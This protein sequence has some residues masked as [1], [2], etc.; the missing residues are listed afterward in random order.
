MRTRIASDLHDEV[1]S[2]LSGLS[3]QAELLEMT[4][5][6]KDNTTLQHIG[7]IS[8][9]AVSKMRDLVWSIDSRRDK[10]KNLLDRMR[11]HADD[12]LQPREISCR[13]ELGDLPLEKKLPVDMR[14]HLFLIFKEA[15]NNVARH[16]KAT[17]VK[18][19]F[20]N[21]DGKLVLCIHDN[22]TS[23]KNE[24]IATGL[25]LSNM[26]MRAAKLGANLQVERHDGF[27]I[28]LSLKA[29]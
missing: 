12:L 22:G 29:L 21:F 28:R 16:S 2:M 8:R 9:T 6:D 4:S 7:D 1:G 27:S 11:E 19:R 20:G 10:V 26:E 18:V 15:L 14:Q 24:K 25:G 5:T 17:E 13:F 23:Q 3:M